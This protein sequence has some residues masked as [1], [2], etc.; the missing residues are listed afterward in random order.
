MAGAFAFPSIRETIWG[1]EGPD[2]DLVLETAQ[3]NKFRV[4]I[5]ERGI[6]GSLKNSTLHSR[7]EG[8]TTIIFIV[9]EG[10]QVSKPVPARVTGAITEI[11]TSGDT[12]LVT[13]EGEPILINTP[14]TTLLIPGTTVEHVVPMGKYTKILHEKNS[15]IEADELLAGDVVCELDSSALVDKEKQQR[16]AVTSE[17]ANVEKGRKNV[18][19]QINQN[20]SDVAAAKLK[21]DLAKLDLKKFLEGEKIQQENENKGEVLIAQE[22]LTQAL[23]TYQYFQRIAKKGYKSQ[24][25]LETARVAVVKAQNKL[26]VAEEKLKVLQKYTFERTYKE[27]KENA[28]ESA[29]E[30]KRVELSGLAALAQYRAELKARELAYNVELQKLKRL[31]EQIKAC[32]LIAP[33]DGKVVYANQRSRRSEAVVIEEGTSVRERQAIITLPD[34]SQMK[35]EAKIHESKI[36]G[37]VEGLPVLIKVDAV[38]DKIFKGVVHSVPDV[39]VKGEWPNT[40]MMLYETTIKIL[41]NVDQLK[42][43][44]NAE[45]EIIVE[46]REDVLQVPVQ[47]IINIGDSYAAYVAKGNDVSIRKDIK[48]GSSNNKMVEILAGLEPGEQVVMNPNSHFSK[49]IRALRDN[50]QQAVVKTPP[51]ARKKGKP[52]SG[53]KG[54]PKGK[55]KGGKR[56]GNYSPAAIFKNMDKNGDG[57]ITKDEAPPQMASSF[58]KMDANKDGGIDQGELQKAFARMRKRSGGRP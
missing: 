37:I 10:T 40:D 52:T 13:V 33:Q 2:R 4:S 36:S 46:D 5:T 22:E 24:V 12:R 51:G 14:W 43:G 7:V 41:G 49:E 8:S 16:I 58:D 27:L 35:V 15:R 34:F 28:E 23:E 1:P 56:P 32:T 57:K 9:P 11:Q 54:A 20:L 30:L 29:R 25:E 42:P 31:Q 38:P 44:M 47:S 19:I 48:I 18:E 53:K 50:V 17:E 45:V 26:A 3:K 21:L 39:P 55:K 6:L